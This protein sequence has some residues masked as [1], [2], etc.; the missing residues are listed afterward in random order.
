M[1]FSQEPSTSAADYGGPYPSSDER[2]ILLAGEGGSQPVKLS[3]SDAQRIEEYTGNAPADL[4]DYD[5]KQSMR[6]LNIYSAPLTEGDYR[7]LF[8]MES[9]SQQMS[10]ET[11]IRHHT[12]PQASLEEQLSNLSDIRQKGLITEDEYNAKKK[13]ILG[14]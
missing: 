1:L 2:Y 6:E 11:V 8:G 9:G 4:E 14:I 13:L 5:L 10:G 7:T 12:A 3:L